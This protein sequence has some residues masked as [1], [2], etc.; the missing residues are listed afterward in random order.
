MALS[1]RPVKENPPGSGSS[2]NSIRVSQK[3]RKTHRTLEIYFTT[4][5]RLKLEGASLFP[6]A[7]GEGEGE[8]GERLTTQRGRQ[9][10]FV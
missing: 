3:N 4:T 6:Q 8:E 5:A 7:Y 9:R 10:L 2:H 1:L